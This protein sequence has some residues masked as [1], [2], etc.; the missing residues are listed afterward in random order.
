MKK[1]SDNQLASESGAERTRTNN[2]EM[3]K[4][5]ILEIATEEFSSNGFAGARVDAIAERTRTT[6]RAIYYYFGSKEGLYIAVLSKVYG[7]IRKIESSMNLENIDAEQA[8]R[9]L[10][11]FTMDYQDTHP[12]FVRIVSIE[13]INFGKYIKSLDDIKA[14]NS[15]IIDIIKTILD[16]GY[17]TGIFHRRTDP[18]DV[19]MLISA[20]SFFRVSN[21]YTFEALFQH[22][23]SDPD[24][25]ARHKE[26]AADM[27][28]DLLKKKPQAE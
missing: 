17:E 16:H 21:H 3:T 2:P 15:R 11:A 19:H 13:N 28:V 8:I 27:I 12:D 18:L 22:D 26:M 25:R 5:D 23:L 14:L 10:I 7:D 6:K 4:A 9:Q 20:L 24:V 1:K